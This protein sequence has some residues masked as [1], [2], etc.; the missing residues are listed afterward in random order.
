MFDR[1]ALS[2]PGRIGRDLSFYRL[3]RNSLRLARACSEH[4]VRVTKLHTARL[5]G[6]KRLLGAFADE[7]SLKLCN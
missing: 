2:L 5:G 4:S 3:G 6:C 7:A 1:D